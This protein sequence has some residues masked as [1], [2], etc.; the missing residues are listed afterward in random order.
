MHFS[1]TTIMKIISKTEVA[2]LQVCNISDGVPSSS[3]FWSGFSVWV[4]TAASTGAL[5]SSSSSSSS[6]EKKDNYVK[7]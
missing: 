3:S 2:R 5:S 7:H 1:A 6:A 4:S